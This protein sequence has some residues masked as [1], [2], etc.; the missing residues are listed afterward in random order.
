MATLDFSRTVAA[1]PETVWE[2]VADLRGM[3]DF[4]RF[5]RV[6]LER[7]GD[8][9]PNGVGAIR[10]LHLVG[11]PVREEIIA[12]EPP[13]RLAYRMLSGV[14]VKAHVGTVELE[15]AGEGTRMSYVVETTPK[16]PVIGF[17]VV[18][19][20]RRIIEDIAAGIAAEAETRAAS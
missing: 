3:S 12:F 2:V 9:P 6:E 18:A 11:P 17:A 15:A 14:P 4:T 1:P 19:L 7:E 16:I 8:P 10:V 20:L 5:R 13:R